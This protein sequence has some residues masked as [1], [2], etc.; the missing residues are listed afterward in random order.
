SAATLREA[1][2]LAPEDPQI[3]VAL[4]TSLTAVRASDEAWEE[5]K[6]ITHK[7]EP[8]GT[9]QLLMALLAD[10]PARMQAASEALDKY[11]KSPSAKQVTELFVAMADL[12]LRQGH[13]EQAEQRFNDANQSKLADV[14]GAVRLAVLYGRVGRFAPAELL[15]ES[16]LR[17]APNRSEIAVQL[18][19]VAIQLGHA[20]RADALLS[21][22]PKDKRDDPELALTRGR[23]AL[24]LGRAQEALPLLRAAL[25]QLSPAEAQATMG[26]ELHR[27]IA[28]AA[29]KQGDLPAAIRELE[30]LVAAGKA[31]PET[32]FLLV[33]LR[34]EAG[35][36]DGAIKE[37]NA[38]ASER[39]TQDQA[40]E[41]LGRIYM[42]AYDAEHAEPLLAKL[43]AS[44][45]DNPHAAHVHAGAL[46]ALGKDV[47]AIAELERTLQLDPT[48][49][50]ALASLLSL[51]A[52][53]DGNEP[54]LAF[55][56]T[57]VAAH[58]GSPSIH[59]AAGQFYAD[60]GK[61]EDAEN[62]EALAVRMDP[63]NV[64]A[65]LHYGHVMELRKNPA[66]ALTLY[67]E[68]SKLSP[69]AIEPVLAAG[70][71]LFVL[72]DVE[73][74]SKRFERLL[75]L[76]PNS[77]LALNNL[78]YVYAGVPQL[79]PRAKELA[80]RAYALEPKAPQAADTLGYVL[81]RAGEFD[82]AAPL[83]QA[84]HDG[85]PNNPIVRVHYALNQIALGKKDEG[86]KELEEVLHAGQEFDGASEAREALAKR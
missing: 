80:Q 7:Q 14:W 71:I 70:K 6:W 3:R 5:A 77:S 51:R 4:A 11:R 55:A 78:A 68:A 45:P 20:E 46:R 48:R 29:R 2:K 50:P 83:L 52:K 86:R 56:K 38:L 39:T 62:E 67:D 63:T 60:Q 16:A 27:L 35:D 58:S 64:T 79:L 21:S 10:T 81:Y 82:K 73:G 57:Y 25:A 43:C 61:L 1:K 41:R 37:L 32:R 18:A 47:E 30:S 85:L 40:L 33:S 69:Q 66:R 17:A 34:S 74:A 31:G 26:E 59:V 44:L 9:G 8:L 53:R 36:R 65:W 42:D 22:L 24:A 12:E 13:P 19:H 15:L 72:H 23:T 49:G 54:T 84:A 76:Q 28:E 75:E